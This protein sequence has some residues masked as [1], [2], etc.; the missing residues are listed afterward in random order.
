MGCVDGDNYID[1]E[2]FQFFEQEFLSSG[3]EMTCICGSDVVLR[4]HH[5]T[6][7]AGCFEAGTRFGMA[8]A[9]KIKKV[10]KELEE[11]R[12]KIPNIEGRS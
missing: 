2:D 8:N 7:C 9:E 6:Y 10:D 12:K 1:M 11:I 3:V 4:V 5:K